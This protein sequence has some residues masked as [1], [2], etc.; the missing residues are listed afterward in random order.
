MAKRSLTLGI[1]ESCLAILAIRFDSRVGIRAP[2]RNIS[3]GSAS[4]LAAASISVTSHINDDATDR[5]RPNTRRVSSASRRDMAP[6]RACSKDVS[7]AAILGSLPRAAPLGD[8]SAS[9]P[10]VSVSRKRANVCSLFMV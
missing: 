4:V 1:S 8:F 6:M 10:E 9:G 5:I 2:C 7:A 3:A